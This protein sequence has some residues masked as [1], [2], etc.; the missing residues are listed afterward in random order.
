MSN[1]IRRRK[2]PAK[3]MLIYTGR[4]R[5]R[6]RIFFLLTFVVAQCEHLVEFPVN[7]FG[8]DFAFALALE[9]I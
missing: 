8:N 2:D 4:K 9:L 6:K 5:T 1:Q 7:Q 3:S